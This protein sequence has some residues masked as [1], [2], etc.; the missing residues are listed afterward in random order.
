MGLKKKIF[1]KRENFILFVG[2][3]RNYKNFNLLLN[4][5]SKSDFLKK[6]FKIIFFWRR[7]NLMKK[8]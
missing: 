5:F 3:R 2:D 6:K 7:K 4:A 1:K 8:N